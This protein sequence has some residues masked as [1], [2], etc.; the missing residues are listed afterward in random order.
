MEVGADQMFHVAIVKHQHRGAGPGGGAPGVMMVQESQQ[1]Q[2]KNQGPVHLQKKLNNRP[3]TVPADP[4]VVGTRTQ[5][6]ATGAARNHK[7]EQ[8]GNLDPGHK[9]LSSKNHT[10]SSTRGKKCKSLSSR[11]GGLVRTPPTTPRSVTAGGIPY[12][13]RNCPRRRTLRYDQVD[14]HTS[15]FF[16]T[17]ARIRLLLVGRFK[18]IK[19]NSFR[20]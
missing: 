19:T 3:M 18:N 6:H 15:Q 5:E 14:T 13:P 8:S 20:I 16:Y 11:E 2:K 9:N 7:I 10:A 12:S 1:V 17:H 4:V